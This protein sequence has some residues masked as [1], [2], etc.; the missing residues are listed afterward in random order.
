[1]FYRYRLA[2]LLAVERIRSRIAIDLHDDIGS[3][4]SQMA[5]LSE[6][7]RRRIGDSDAEIDVPLS[8][9]GVIS[10]ELVDSMSDIVWA[11]NP[12]KD[13]LYFLTQRM[14]DFVYCT[15]HSI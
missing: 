9:I 1:V 2:Q 8:R 3:S 14:R 12:A 7:V 6:V 15:R 5:I 11:I 13:K 10:R 4:L